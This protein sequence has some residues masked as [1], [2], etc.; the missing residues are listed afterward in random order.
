MLILISVHTAV[1]TLAAVL[2]MVDV[3]GHVICPA[4]VVVMELSAMNEVNRGSI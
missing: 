4:L 2:A 1:A 3:Q